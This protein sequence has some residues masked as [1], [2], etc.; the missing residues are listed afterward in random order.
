MFVAIT[1][2]LTRYCIIQ[3]ILYRSH[4]AYN[5]SLQNFIFILVS[6]VLIAG[7]GNIINDYFDQN[8]DQIN[9][10]HKTI[11]GKKIKEE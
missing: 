2:I 5:L 8:I 11:V 3:P 9:K 6:S 1:Q 4:Q 7:G 10:P